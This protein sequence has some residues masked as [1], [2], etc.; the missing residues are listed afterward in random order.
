M[1]AREWREKSIGE[2]ESTLLEF[3]DKLR[4]LRF[5]IAS[6]ETKNHREYR[7]IRKDIAR[8][9]TIATESKEA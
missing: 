7:K 3:T 8:L 5:E 1:K 2:R 4:T 9:N 6:R